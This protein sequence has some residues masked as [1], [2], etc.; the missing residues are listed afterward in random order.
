MF[1]VK[2]KYYLNFNN[3]SQVRNNNLSNSNTNKK[4]INKPKT[5]GFIKPPVFTRT[6][7]EMLFYNNH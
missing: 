4:E 1:W 7:E 6:E 2:T 3:W 5:Y